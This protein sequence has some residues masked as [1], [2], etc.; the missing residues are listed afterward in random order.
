MDR[1]KGAAAEAPQP[2][3]L[4]EAPSD[5]V[6]GKLQF[7]QQFEEV[8]RDRYLVH[9]KKMFSKADVDDMKRHLLLDEAN[10]KL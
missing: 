4:A 6:V 7:Q 9:G 8:T 5:L 10:R 2:S 3:A 1:V